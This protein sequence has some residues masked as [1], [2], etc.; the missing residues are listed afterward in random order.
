MEKGPSENKLKNA[1]VESKGSKTN[2][3]DVNFH[4]THYRSD[5]R[6]G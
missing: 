6:Q 1:P 4:F 2:Q 5:V 3:G